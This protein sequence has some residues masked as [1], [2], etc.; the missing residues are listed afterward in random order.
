MGVL[1]YGAFLSWLYIRQR[2]LLFPADKQRTTP[3][4]AGLPA[5]ESV[6]ITPDLTS[7][8]HAP[9]D[10]RAP[11][12]LYFQGNGGALAGRARLFRD[13]A[14]WGYGVLAVGYPGYGGNPGAPSE[15]RLI[16]AAKANHDWLT[17]KGIAPNRIILYGHSM[18]S[19]VATGLAVER[20]AAG[21]I[22]E[23]PFTSL[24]DV[25]AL[26][27]PLVPAG[28]L[29]K[30]KFQ[31]AKRITRVKMPVVWVHGDQ[32][33]LIPANMGR[34][35]YD[36]I[37]GEKCGAVIAGGDHDNLWGMGMDQIVRDQAAKIV[38]SG[39]CQI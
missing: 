4:A 16:A 30:D 7:W 10:D 1:A 28:L 11:I 31:S 14:S 35:L 36:R 18:G 26:Q 6:A 8:W 38:A 32:D 13:M 19:G 3:A 21:L 15:D 29:T 23:S 22:L 39:R 12:I 37:P 27:M 34:R 20:P 33:R 2:D 25:V 5:F 24:A 17:A 9:A